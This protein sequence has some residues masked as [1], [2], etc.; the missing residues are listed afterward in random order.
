MAELVKKLFSP[1]FSLIFMMMGNGLLN[2]FIPLRLDFESVTN[3]KIG[4]IVSSLYVGILIGSI[5]I[6]R[7][8]IR[9]GFIRSYHLFA[10]SM[11]LFVLLQLLS[12]NFWIWCVLRFLTGLCLSGIFVIVESWVLL[13][14]KK[15][16]RGKMLSIY[17]AIFYAALSIGQLLINVASIEDNSFFYLCSFLFILS[18]LPIAL[19]KIEAPTIENSPM[20]TIKQLFKFSPIGFLGGVISGMILAT[21]YGLVPI[22]A[23]EIGLSIFEISL[24]M[25]FIIFGGFILQWPLGKKADETDRNQVLTMVAFLTCFICFAIALFG[26]FSFYLLLLLAILY[27]G[28]SFTLYPLS[29]AYTCE[30][31]NE[32]QVVA[33]T[34]GFVLSYSIGAVLGPVIAP[35]FMKVF[36]ASGVF[37]FL[38]LISFFLGLGGV[39]DRNQALSKE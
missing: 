17:L 28:F 9:L 6:H 36:E 27:G 15:E 10:G 22:Y 2:T 14:S 34:A 4:I 26:S 1:L 30:K 13:E 38:A 24:L 25:T 16:Q 20:L 29:M 37:Y 32:D 7:A 31:I 18:Q 3:E 39:K 35:I 11:G 5:F 21:T 19:T 8:I 33:A 23:T 12:S